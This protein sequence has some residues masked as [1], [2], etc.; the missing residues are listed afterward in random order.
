[1]RRRILAFKAALERVR[2][3]STQAEE[4]RLPSGDMVRLVHEPRTE[5][6]YRIEPM[7]GTESLEDSLPQPVVFDGPGVRPPEY[8]EDLPFLPGQSV[9][10]L[11]QGPDGARLLAWSDLSDATKA[12]ETI[13]VQLEKEGWT[14]VRR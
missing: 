3:G 1:M 2:S 11:D 5:A 4:V 6:G 9:S 8:P 12:L 7:P 10:L 13:R 14:L